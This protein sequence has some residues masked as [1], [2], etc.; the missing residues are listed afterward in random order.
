M[1][2]SLSVC[3]G[4]GGGGWV[5]LCVHACVNGGHCLCC[6]CVVVCFQEIMNLS[7]CA[8]QYYLSKI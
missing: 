5:R 1:S 7:N 2:K 8:K 3:R 4:G 6:C